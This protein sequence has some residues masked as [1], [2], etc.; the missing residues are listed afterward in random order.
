V[1]D[2]RRQLATACP[3]LASLLPHVL[4]AVNAQYAGDDTVIPAGAEL[5]CIPPVSGG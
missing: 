5:A 1:A 3:E 2:L 4:I